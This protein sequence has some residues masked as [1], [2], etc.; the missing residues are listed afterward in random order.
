MAYLRQLEDIR[1]PRGG[2][3]L[4]GNSPQ[5]RD[6]ESG[7]EWREGDLETGALCSIDDEFAVD[8]VDQSFDESETKCCRRIDVEVFGQPNTIIGDDELKTGVGF[9]QA[10]GYVPLGT[11]KRILKGI[12][13]E[14]VDDQTTG[15]RLVEGKRELV[16]F[17][18]KPYLC[19]LDGVGSEDAAC[20]IID[21]V[22]KID[23]GQIFG[24]IELFVDQSHRPDP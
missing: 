10:Y 1:H 21:I 5:R 16:H 9:R 17:G 23:R 6:G 24:P 4:R 15:N 8:L 11:A 19:G 14:F 13:D 12:T 2:R 3:G 20:E 22:A 18:C 7:V